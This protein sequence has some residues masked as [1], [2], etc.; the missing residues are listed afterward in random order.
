MERNAALF[1]ALAA[2][3]LHSFLLAAASANAATITVNG[4]I[5]NITGVTTSFANDTL[6]LESQVWYNNRPLARDFAT[7][8]IVQ[9]PDGTGTVNFLR[10]AGSLFSSALI[11]NPN[12]PIS[13]GISS[14]V[15]RLNIRRTYAVGEFVGL[16]P[17]PVPA[18]LPLLAA[19]LAVFGALGFY[20]RRN[21]A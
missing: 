4:E 1:K 17:V 11:A 12:F 19:G 10:D 8:Y 15:D 13:Q 6:L 5:W 14:R 18:T 3:V 7:A 16:T 9:V 21:V 20:S 2:I